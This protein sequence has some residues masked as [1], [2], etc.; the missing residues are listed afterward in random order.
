[1]PA[2]SPTS[3]CGLGAKSNFGGAPQRRISTLSVTK[4]PR[5]T[6]ECGTLGMV[7]RRSRCLASSSPMRSSDCL[8]RSETCFISAM[9]ES[10]FCFPFLRRAIS[11]LALLRWA[12]SCS[13]AVM[14]SRR[15]LSSLRK[16]SRSSTVPRFFAI[17]AK[18]SSCSLKKVRSC[19]ALEGYRN[20]H[21][22][23]SAGFESGIISRVFLP[24]ARDLAHQFHDIPFRIAEPHHPQIVNWHR[25]DQ[26]RRRH[27]LHMPLEK[28]LVRG[29][30]ILHPE[31]EDGARMIELRR[32][33]GAKH[34]AHSATIKESQ[35]AGREEQ[36]QTQGVT[37]KCGGALQVVNDDGDLADVGDSKVCRCAVHW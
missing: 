11:S 8:M 34:Q 36:W 24:R 17:S 18:R 27:D 30:D 4:C 6:E 2:R 20:P 22:P 16:A 12:L 15:S 21:G 35:V 9:R 7:S 14:S 26:A 29:V 1:M 32:F 31:V 25:S 10:A 13:V 28:K 5:G 23:C 19:M 3:Q 33:R 37:V